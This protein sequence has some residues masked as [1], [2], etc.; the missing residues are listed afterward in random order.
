[1]NG[2]AD[3]TSKMI[4]PDNLY[5]NWNSAE[6]KVNNIGP[7][8]F[9]TLNDPQTNGGLL[10]S[11]SRDHSGDF[12][13]FLKENGLGDFSKPIGEIISKHTFGIEIE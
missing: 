10:V 3:Y 7:E 8:S 4:V 5:R 12:E 1:M 11:V 6:K 2:I 9:F 13:K